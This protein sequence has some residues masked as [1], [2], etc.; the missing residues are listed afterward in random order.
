MAGER[1]SNTPAVQ[2]VGK[3]LDQLKYEIANEMNATLGAD[4]TSRENGTVGGN[5]TKRMIQFAEQQ[6][7]NGQRI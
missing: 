1:N 3:G 4:R 5:M 7:K 6:L 2:G